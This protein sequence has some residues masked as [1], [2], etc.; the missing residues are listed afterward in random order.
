MFSFFHCCFC[1][2]FRDF[3]FFIKNGRTDQ[4]VAA[5]LYFKKPEAK[6]LIKKLGIDN[7]GILKPIIFL[8][9]YIG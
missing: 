9:L 5:K 2:F 8:C 1:C 3:F 6:K 7:Q 4:G